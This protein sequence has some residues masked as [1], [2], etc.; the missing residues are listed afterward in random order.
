MPTNSSGY[1][2]I[3]IF[4]NGNMTARNGVNL[5]TSTDTG[6]TWSSQILPRSNIDDIAL[7]W[8]NGNAFYSPGNAVYQTTNSG[9][10]WSQIHTSTD[11][12]RIFT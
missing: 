4:P 9:V 1:V 8:G 6:A 5:L 7:L 12:M 10:S 11:V 2:A 3:A